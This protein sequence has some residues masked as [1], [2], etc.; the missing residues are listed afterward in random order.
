MAGQ[1]SLTRIGSV[2]IAA[3]QSGDANWL[4]ATVITNR[5]TVGR[6]VQVVTFKPIGDQTLGAGPLKLAARAGSGLPATFSVLNGQAAVN[7]QQLTV[8]GEGIVTGASHPSVIAKSASSVTTGSTYWFTAKS[9]IRQKGVPVPRSAC[10]TR[11]RSLSLPV[12]P[13]KN[14]ASVIMRVGNQHLR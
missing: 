6:R 2:M 5:F 1:M 14:S 10:T 11:A 9:P 12:M 13:A 4:A 3:E 7:D 8:L